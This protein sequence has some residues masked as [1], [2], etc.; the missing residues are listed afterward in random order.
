MIKGMWSKQYHVTESELA[1]VWEAVRG[2]NGVPFL[3]YAAG[4][5]NEHKANGERLNLLPIVEKMRRDVNF[6]IIG[7]DKDQFEPRQVAL[8][9]ERISKY[10]V[11]IQVLPGGH[12]II[13]EQPQLLAD[14]ILTIANNFNH[15]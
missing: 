2:R 5:V 11:D 8:A 1:E 6:Y 14:K 7:S 4:F 12:M 15:Q 13:M 10:G 3:H 9:K